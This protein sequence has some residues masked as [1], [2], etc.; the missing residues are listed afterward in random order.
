MNSENILAKV[1]PGHRRGVTYQK[2]PRTNA[3]LKDMSYVRKRGETARCENYDRRWPESYHDV[4][5]T[6]GALAAAGAAAGAGA[7]AGAAAAGLPTRP[8]IRW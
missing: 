1:E 8:A 2:K 6:C 7:G 4:T 3:E 5:V